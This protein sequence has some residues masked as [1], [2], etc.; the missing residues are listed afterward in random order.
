MHCVVYFFPCI[1]GM[2]SSLS[3]LLR[4]SPRRILKIFTKMMTTQ[5]HTPRLAD[6]I[7]YT[8]RVLK[9]HP[10]FP[11]MSNLWLLTPYILMDI[12]SD[13]DMDDLMLPTLDQMTPFVK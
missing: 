6:P 4:P 13:D 2:N 10:N 9:K 12:S 3:M 11:P 8:A 1:V 5:T 7:N